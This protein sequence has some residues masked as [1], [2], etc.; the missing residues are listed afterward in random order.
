MESGNEYGEGLSL[1]DALSGSQLELDMI[2]SEDTDEWELD[3]ESNE[4]IAADNELQDFEDLVRDLQESAPDV[5]LVERLQQQAQGTSNEFDS[6][7]FDGSKLT[8]FDSFLLL[9]H[10]LSR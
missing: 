3:I 1:S 2:E 4:S 10:F 8:V 7:L 6:P 9:M 5:P